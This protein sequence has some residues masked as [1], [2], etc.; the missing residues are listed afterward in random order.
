M[1]VITV[2]RN[3]FVSS[4]KQYCNTCLS[5]EPIDKNPSIFRIIKDGDQICNIF[6][7]TLRKINGA[8]IKCDECKKACE[9]FGREINES[10]KV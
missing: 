7:S 6:N 4:D 5:K 2:Q 8:Y 10:K 1:T 9:K 3:Y